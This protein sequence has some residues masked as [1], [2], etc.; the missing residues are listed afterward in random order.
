MPAISLTPLSIS[1]RTEVSADQFDQPQFEEAI[2]DTLREAQYFHELIIIDVPLGWADS[3]W[4]LEDFERSLRMAENP[5][6]QGAGLRKEPGALFYTPCERFPR[7][8]AEVGWSESYNDMLD[9]M[10]KV[11]DG[12]NGAIRVVLLVTW[13]K[14]ANNR[15]SGV[16]ELYR[17]D[18]DPKLR[19]TEVIFPIPAGDPL[20]GLDI[21]GRDLY[22]VPPNRN[23]DERF[24]LDIRRLRYIARNSLAREGL[25]LLSRPS[26]FETG[27]GIT[28]A[29]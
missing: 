13:T 17:H 18:H 9:D 8:I 26:L 29:D 6:I 22:D 23:A 10:N 21:Q 14:H 27:I 7:L 20:Q 28:N 24:P 25:C 19:Q 16:L 2:L 11:L 5:T 3:L 15:V 12:G 4:E 1:S